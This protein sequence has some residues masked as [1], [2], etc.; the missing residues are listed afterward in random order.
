M[1]SHEQQKLTA[2]TLAPFNKPGSTLQVTNMGSQ[3][4]DP[5]ERFVH[6]GEIERIWI[7]GEGKDAALKARFKWIAEKTE[8]GGWRLI[9]DP[10]ALDFYYSL[11][12]FCAVMEPD[13]GR[14]LLQA[15]IPISHE[16]VL[17]IASTYVGPTGQT[18]LR[19]EEVTPAS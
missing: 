16:N 8:D 14:L 7:E 3:F 4:V 12:L 10:K 6:E 11:M 15:R 19:R 2:D 13:R 1:D 17:L 18:P 9:E 5:H